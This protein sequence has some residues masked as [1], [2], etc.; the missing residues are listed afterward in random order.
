MSLV[1]LFLGSTA[2]VIIGSFLPWINLGFESVSG[3]EGGGL[4]TLV[5]AII[6]VIA[7]FGAK[8]KHFAPFI[9]TIIGLLTL[10]IVIGT[11]MQLKE[12]GLD[13]QELDSL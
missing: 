4:Y 12:V 13:L 9:T 6:N 3:I 2:V 8:D 5:L 7:Y 11:S 1:Y 10:F